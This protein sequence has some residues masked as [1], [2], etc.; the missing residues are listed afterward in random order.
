MNRSKANR[1]TPQRTRLQV[2]S[3]SSHLTCCRQFT[4]GEAGAVSGWKD[5]GEEGKA[6]LTL[7]SPRSCSNEPIQGEPHHTAADEAP[8]NTRKGR[9]GQWLQYRGEEGKAALTLISPRSCSNEPIQGEPHHTAADEAPGTF[10][11]LAPHLLLAVNT[12]RGRSGQ[13]LQV[14]R[15]GRQGGFDIDQPKANRTTPQRTRL[16]V[17]SASSHLTCC[18][19]FTRGEAGAVSG[20]KDHGEEGKAALTLISPRSCSNEPIQGEPHHTAADEAP[21]PFSFS[22][23]TCCRQL[24]RGKAGA[25]RGEEG[26]AANQQKPT[27]PHTHH[28]PP[29]NTNRGEEGK[30]ALTLISP[31]SCSNEPIQGEPHHTA[32][33]EAPGTFSYL[34]PHLLLA[35]NTRRGRSGQWLQVPRRGRQGGFDIDQPKANRTTPQRTRLQV[36]SASSHLTCCRQFTRGEVGAVSGWK[37]HGE[38]GKAALTLISPRSCS[39]EPIQGE[40]HHTAADEAPGQLILNYNAVIE[41]PSNLKRNVESEPPISRLDCMDNPPTQFTR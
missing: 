20:W 40:P 14:P 27:T 21:G 38:E 13:W 22:H 39:N 34:A 18:R 15:R 30:A 1:T 36:H 23:L 17:H 6:A 9:S 8:V 12:R 32:A 2:H 28:P 3:A 4:R 25:Y 37:D 41:T 5:H 31:R 10:S 33:D 29:H 26:K 16:Q 7:I 35:V 19:Q 11:Y 24:T